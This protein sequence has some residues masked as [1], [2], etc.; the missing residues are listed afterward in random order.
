MTQETNVPRTD[1]STVADEDSSE[2][3]DHSS[4]SVSEPKCSKSNQNG[5]QQKSKPVTIHFMRKEAKATVIPLTA[6][7]IQL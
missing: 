3:S 5:S 2:S 1:D 4:E 6:K 7:K